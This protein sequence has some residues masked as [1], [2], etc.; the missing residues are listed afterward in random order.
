MNIENVLSWPVFGD[1][2]PNLD[3]K[4]LLND[5]NDA[6]SQITP[7]VSDFE[8]F[9]EEEL[10]QRFLDHVLIFNPVLEETKVQKY[11]RDAR[12]TGFG[13]D[14]QSCLLVK[15]LATLYFSGELTYHSFSSMPMAR[16][17]GVP[18]RDHLQMLPKLDKEHTSSR[19]NRSSLLLR[20]D[21][22]CSCVAA[23]SWKHS[24]SS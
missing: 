22:V 24:A 1:Q 11:I 7:M 9:P 5:S 15:C 16:L 10:V 20:E 3:L 23:G 6:A 14:A 8:H 2:N 18:N 4:S 13:W 12:F 17:P 19:P 21:L